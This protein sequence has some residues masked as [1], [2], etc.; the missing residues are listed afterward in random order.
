[1]FFLVRGSLFKEFKTVCSLSSRITTAWP[2]VATDVTGC[3][4][5]EW[6]VEDKEGG[7]DDDMRGRGRETERNRERGKNPNYVL[8]SFT[9]T[10][11][12]FEDAEN[13]V[14]AARPNFYMFDYV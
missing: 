2:H 11:G 3:K 4:V 14:I 12:L 1:M 7:C 5:S 13:K 9:S 10:A 8:V 6:G